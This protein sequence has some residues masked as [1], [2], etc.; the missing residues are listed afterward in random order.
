[1]LDFLFFFYLCG[2]VSCGVFCLV[3]FLMGF[4]CLVWFLCNSDVSVLFG[5]LFRLI[6]NQKLHI[7]C[8]EYSAK[9]YLISTVSITIMTLFFSI[10]RLQVC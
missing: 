6:F 9:I 4:F 8:Q 7:T 5:K 10:L 2:C 3:V 1:M